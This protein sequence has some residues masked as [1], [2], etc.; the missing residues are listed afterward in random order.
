MAASGN[1]HTDPNLTVQR[2]QALSDGCDY[3]LP[4]AFGCVGPWP[5]RD[6]DYRIGSNFWK[7]YLMRTGF[8]LREP[9][10]LVKVFRLFRMERM[11]LVRNCLRTLFKHYT[12]PAFFFFFFN[13]YFYFYFY[14]EAAKFR[15]EKYD[16]DLYK[17][18]SMAQISQISKEKI[19]GSPDFQYKFQ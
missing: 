17:G 3:S 6:R 16:F 11:F 9:V 15:P 7:F 5:H 8:T 12:G 19:S 18:F 14:F 4:P 2:K 10:S 1:F 13:F